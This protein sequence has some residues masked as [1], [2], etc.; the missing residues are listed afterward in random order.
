MWRSVKQFVRKPLVV[1][2]STTLKE[3][4]EKFAVV[5]SDGGS[6]EG[7]VSERDIVRAP[8]RAVSGFSPARYLEIRARPSSDMPRFADLFVEELR[9]KK[10]EVLRVVGAGADLASR[11][12]RLLERVWVGGVCAKRSFSRVFAVDS[13]SDEV[14]VAG[15]GVLLVTRSVALST[16]GSELRRLRLDALFPRSV[17][18]YED[19]KRLLREHLEH[20]AALDALEGGA[21]LVLLD[22]SLYGRM[23]HVI[24]ELEVEGREDFL[25]E[26]VETYGELLTRA[27]KAGVVV[28]GVSKDSRSTVLKEELLL[29]E[30]RRLLSG[31]DSHVREQVMALWESLRRRPRQALEAL[32]RLLREGLDPAVYE[33]FE[34]ARRATPDSKIIMAVGLG[35]GYTL[36]LRLSL[37]RVSM[38][39]TDLVVRGAREE[40]ALSLLEKVFPRAADRDGEAF[41]GRAASVLERLRSY[42][43]VF[44]TYVVFSRGDD[45]VRVDVVA[46]GVAPTLEGSRLLSSVP[47]FVERVVSHL[48]CM[49]AGRQGYNML[50]LEA[51]RRVRTTP[52]S[53]ELYHKLAMKELSELILH[54][55][56]ERRFY[57]P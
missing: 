48:A 18:D 27:L 23:I 4:A 49:Y 20:L 17:R 39:I 54:S 22:G 26:Y 51:D 46:A 50:L 13:G 12:S 40:V 10:E 53:M 15:G 31:V 19:F 41:R 56:R 21:E 47:D 2:P 44:T 28:A 8:A 3:L 25:L 7:V 42:P 55:R 35:A 9:R 1:P 33:V 16:D 11:Y 6:V 38:G 45:P 37:E 34:E 43:P 57:T 29:S 32:R 5:S 24:R 30:L 14:E 52:E 36:P